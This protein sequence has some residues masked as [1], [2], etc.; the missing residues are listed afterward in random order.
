MGHVQAWHDKLGSSP[1]GS[2]LAVSE[3]TVTTT[4]TL[5]QKELHHCPHRSRPRTFGPGSSD[6]DGSCAALCCGL[7]NF[8]HRRLLACFTSYM[9]A[10]VASFSLAQPAAFLLGFPALFCWYT[11]G[12]GGCYRV[13]PDTR[14]RCFIKNPSAPLPLYHTTVCPSID[15]T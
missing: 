1:G 2:S 12:H 5:P 3:P 11:C 7:R 9:A 13:S 6:T 8:L 10:A 14:A 4:R 15:S